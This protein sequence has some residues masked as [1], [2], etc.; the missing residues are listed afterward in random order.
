VSFERL[1]KQHLLPSQVVQ[2]RINTLDAMQRSLDVIA[3][4]PGQSCD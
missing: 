2:D 1:K 4:K 3:A